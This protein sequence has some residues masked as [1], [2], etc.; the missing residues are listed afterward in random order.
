MIL[1]HAATTLVARRAAPEMPWWLLLVSA[2]F[3]DIVMFTLVGL[4][5][6]TMA[7]T[8]EP[9]PTMANAVVDMTFSHDLIPQFGWTLLVGGIAFALMRRVAFALVAMAL[10]L[11]HWLGD[12][13][14][15]YGHF[16]F[17]PASHPLGT[18]WYHLNL[19]AA[20]SFEAAL[21]VLC[22]FVFTRSRS[23]SRRALAGLYV[24]FGAVPFVFLFI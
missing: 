6:E 17:G 4:G 15:G 18:N 19:P 14:A 12:L 23:F 1:G 3:I 21:G 22:V 10:T 24:L 9:G 2:F 5:I 16:V 13:V 20:L 11:G 8:G 7:P